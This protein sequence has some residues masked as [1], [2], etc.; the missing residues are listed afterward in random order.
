[1]LSLKS[2]ME[3]RLSRNKSVIQDCTTLLT[4]LTNR[5]C[6][7]PEP[8]RSRILV[9]CNFQLYTLGKTTPWFS[10]AIIHLALAEQTYQLEQSGQTRSLP[11]TLVDLNDPFVDPFKLMNRVYRHALTLATL[12]EPSSVELVGIPKQHQLIKLASS[13]V[14]EAV[15]EV[16]MPAVQRLVLA[17]ILRIM[18]DPKD[19]STALPAAALRLSTEIWIEIF[20][21]DELTY[22]DLKRLTRVCK[23]FHEIEKHHPLDHRLFR[24]PP[25][26]NPIE[27]DQSVRFHPVLNDTSLVCTSLE[28][29][30]VY[31]RNKQDEDGSPFVP[32]AT[33]PCVNEFAT[34]PA[35]KIVAI[36]MGGKPVARNSGGVTVKDV[37][38]ASAAM[39]TSKP[40]EMT[41][42]SMADWLFEECGADE[43][44]IDEVTWRDTLGDHCFW[45]GMEGARCTKKGVVWLIPQWF[46]S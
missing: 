26:A 23:R 44:D 21:R 18:P 46:G 6:A 43:V 30:N 3:T 8:T 12:F 28:D 11:I 34:S 25:P 5:D 42:F 37:V 29:A 4:T 10:I 45:E 13:R 31:L 17:D 9:L 15:E 16:D 22:Q 14:Q 2:E 1:M 39:W 41:L 33:F 7:I 20:E 35:C 27:K 19:E 24:S 32:V 40:D 36:K 38:E